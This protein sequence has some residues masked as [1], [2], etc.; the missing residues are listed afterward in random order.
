MTA[1][2]S[3]RSEDAARAGLHVVQ[4]PTA[5]AD[6]ID[7]YLLSL[8]AEAKSRGTLSSYGSAL[9][10]LE[11]FAAARGCTDP[12]Q[13]TPDL[14]RAALAATMAEGRRRIAEHRTLNNNKGGEGQARIMHAA[15]RGLARYLRAQDVLIDDFMGVRAVKMP[16]RIQPRIRPNDFL[17]L[18][19]AAA[20]RLAAVEGRRVWQTRRRQS[21]APSFVALREDALIRFLADTGLRAM[22]VSRLDV[23]D[24]NLDRGIVTVRQ[25]KGRKPR[26]L[27]I[28]DPN[29][30]DGGPTVAALRRYADER[31]TTLHRLR[32]T[33][34]GFWIGPRGKRLSPGSLRNALAALCS[35]AGLDG[36]RPPHAFRRGWFTE[37]YKSDPR[38][39]PLLRAR[40]GWSRA[41]EQLV[42]VYTRGA[43]LELSAEP[44]PSLSGRWAQQLQ[45]LE[46]AHTSRGVVQP[47][48]ASAPHAQ[49]IDRPPTPARARA[50]KRVLG[51]R[52]V[53]RSS[54]SSP[55]P[56]PSVD[57]PPAPA[58]QTK[59]QRDR[60]A[61]PTQPL[62]TD[63]FLTPDQ[64]AELL[65]VDGSTVRRW[66][67][68][69]YLPA[70]QLP[71]PRGRYRVN[72]ADALALGQQPA[73]AAPATS[74]A[75]S[76]KLSEKHERGTSKTAIAPDRSS[77]LGSSANA[78]ARPA[79]SVNR[80]LV[81]R[82]ARRASFAPPFPH[83]RKR[84]LQPPSPKPAV[85]HAPIDPRQDV[86]DAPE[87]IGWQ[88]SILTAREA[89]VFGLI[90]RGLTNAAIA[91]ELGVAEMTVK[92]HVA[93]ILR[94]LHVS[95]RVAA[96]RHVDDERR[97]MAIP[98]T[99]SAQAALPAATQSC[100]P[101]PELSPKAAQ[102]IRLSKADRAVLELLVDGLP[103]ATMCKRL[104]LSESTVK[105]RLVRTYR[106]L[107]VGN[108][109][110]AVSRVLNERL[111]EA[112]P[113]EPRRT[114]EL[115]RRQ[116]DVLELLPHGL[117][118]EQIGRRL[119]ISAES[120][121]DHVAAVY[122]KLGVSNRTAV[123]MRAVVL[124][125]LDATAAPA[126]AEATL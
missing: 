46:P 52:R 91:A 97:V 76:D 55:P 2:L 67:S 102:R 51:R 121:K 116:H 75:K 30:P 56:A 92:N 41:S 120:V 100:A 66:I 31:A 50:Q 22:E 45:D 77:V 18:Q 72:K 112:P 28:W 104:G 65:E 106:T 87:R 103:T 93:A 9:R 82:Q 98:P 73:T 36:V 17:A 7:R 58:P 122:R 63:E 32:R 114:L 105:N 14:L 107:G 83:G 49:S 15:A 108:R 8:E 44:R 42:S 125:L 27:S 71:G 126:A 33:C 38:E 20:E 40:M 4:P 124:G 24:V 26:V 78:I 10:Q 47:P 113:D 35:E 86:I 16:E 79:K 101:Q 115:S 109:A 95:N 25:G 110:E 111:L 60:A 5:L 80:R 13:L 70:R 29:L 64:V 3:A 34:D 84:T 94:R 81:P 54:P 119:G 37:S 39:L 57:S 12:Q 43:E 21:T 69:G 117:T 53:L 85:D 96:I 23:V 1:P 6:A 11:R 90:E 99:E 61:A 74:L 48:R 89:E 88:R 118:N 59:R 62:R 19:K 68:R 123:C